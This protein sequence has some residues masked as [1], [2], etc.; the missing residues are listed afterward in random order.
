MNDVPKPSIWFQTPTMKYLTENGAQM[1]DLTGRKSGAVSKSSMKSDCTSK[2][3]ERIQSTYWRVSRLSQ[4]VCLSGS[5]DMKVVHSI[6]RWSNGSIQHGLHAQV[7]NR[8]VKEV[9]VWFCGQ[10]TEVL[11]RRTSTG[12]DAFSPFALLYYREK[13]MGVEV[14][15][16]HFSRS[17][18]RSIFVS[19]SLSLSSLFSFFYIKSAL[20]I[21]F[22]GVMLDPGSRRK[23]KKTFSRWT[24]FTDTHRRSLDSDYYVVLRV[25]ICSIRG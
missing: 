19:V 2:N 11:E 22:M 12:R 23:M 24:T 18:W 3:P 10:C 8:T 21:K 1:N 16:I 13:L 9:L 17:R 7:L 25:S 20:F 4:L 14:Q 5:M 15:P 6:D